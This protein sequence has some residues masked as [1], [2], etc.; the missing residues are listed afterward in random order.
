VLQ[1][2]IEFTWHFERFSTF[3]S[4][5][6]TTYPGNNSDAERVFIG[7]GNTQHAVQ[8]KNQNSELLQQL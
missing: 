1:R 8:S 7:F 2:L 3:S 6:N 5:F 4:D